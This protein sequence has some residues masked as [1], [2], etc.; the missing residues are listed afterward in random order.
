MVEQGQV[1]AT[2]LENAL[3]G[4][5]PTYLQ[6]LQSL[7]DAISTTA[8]TNGSA[9]RQFAIQNAALVDG[10]MANTA[11]TQSVGKLIQVEHMIAV[12][13]A[14]ALPVAQDLAAMCSLGVQACAAQ[15]NV[16]FQDIVASIPELGGTGVGLAGISA[17][18]K[19]AVDQAL[20]KAATEN[21]AVDVGF[22]T[23][24]LES[25]LLDSTR[26]QNQSKANWFSQTLG[27]DQSNWQD[28]ASQL[29]FDTAT[30]V[31]TKTT[32]YGQTFEQTIPITGANGKL[33]NTRIVFMKVYA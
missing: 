17:L 21:I 32:P 12:G 5:E 25:Y 3:T 27:F 23:L 11:F 29:R 24:N 16:I 20:T 1:N 26:P 4:S 33:I 19:E 14:A 8:G 31:A 15:A 2:G 30:A 22:D 9:L 6:L 10:L 7:T 18:D 28:L 13:G